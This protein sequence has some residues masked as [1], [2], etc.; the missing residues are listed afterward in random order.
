MTDKELPK[1][2]G[3]HDRETMAKVVVSMGERPGHREQMRKMRRVL[4]W[5]QDAEQ[6][7]DPIASEVLEEWNAGDLSTDRLYR[8]MRGDKTVALYA[9]LP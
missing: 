3:R 2:L 7:G 1:Y 5:L 4:E 9:R 8:A 6:Q